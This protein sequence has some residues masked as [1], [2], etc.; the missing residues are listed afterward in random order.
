MSAVTGWP[1][2]AGLAWAHGR[3]AAP[4][5]TLTEARSG[6]GPTRWAAAVGLT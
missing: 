3:L 5:R 4:R 2:A 6:A 1:A